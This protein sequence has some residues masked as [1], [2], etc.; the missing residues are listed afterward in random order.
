M[1]LCIVMCLMLLD[2]IIS[3]FRYCP[4][5]ICLHYCLCLLMFVVFSTWMVGS[6]AQTG[7]VTKCNRVAR[8]SVWWLSGMR[9]E[10]RFGHVSLP[11]MTEKGGAAKIGKSTGHERGPRCEKISSEFF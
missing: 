4:N 9:E 6:Q 3:C 2:C 5:C 10:L 8:L 7:Q 11:T 1:L